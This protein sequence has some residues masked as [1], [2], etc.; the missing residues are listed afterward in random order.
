MG[1]ELAKAYVQIIPSAQGIK[2]SLT[3]AIGGEA[4]GAG[5]AAGQSMGGKLVGALKGVLA[6][7]AIGKALAATI[8]EGAA[9]EQSLGGVE[10]LFKEN[11]DTV[12]QY[13]SV[14]YK[15][16]GLSANDYMEQVT[17][18]SASLL[19]SLG[20]DT[21]AA[22]ESANSALVDMSDN[23][24]KFGTAPQSV[25][26]AYQGFAKQNYTMLD[27]LKLGYG[28]TKTEMQ[29]LLADAQKLSGVK[30]DISNLNDV[31]SA[32]HVVQDELNITGTTAKEASSTLSGSLAAMKSAFSN[33]LAGLTLGQDITPALEALADTAI[34][35]LVGNLLPAVWNII[36]ALPGGIAALIKAGAPQLA[37]ALSGILPQISAGISAGLPQLLA[38]LQQ[39]MQQLFA[40]FIANLPI[41]LQ[42]GEQL[43]QQIVN[44]ILMGVT[45]LTE[46]AIP[47][48]TAFINGLVASL[49]MILESGK[50]ILLS[51]LNGIWTA[52]PQLLLAAG[53][54]VL[55]MIGAILVN[56]PQII[57]AG[58]DLLV[59]LVQGFGTAYP[60]MIAAVG[61]L[62][63]NV[64]NAIKEVDWLQL[65]S[66]IV[67][68]IINGIIAMGG[69]L[70]DAMVSIAKSAFDAVANFFGIQSPST[71][72]RDKIGRFIPL[73]IA[74]GI[75]G[76]AK[77][78]SDAMRA[79]ADTTAGQ[80]Q[81]TLAVDVARSRAYAAPLPRDS[82]GFHVKQEIYAAKQT[83][84]EIAATTT[85][86]LR[87]ARWAMA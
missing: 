83:P 45:W 46:A 24:N 59:S 10:T 69:A 33:V 79:L 4:G 19:Q 56:L 34:T 52:L 76:N 78:V 71:L 49:P 27:N 16:A 64:W 62:M 23:W 44:G 7:A 43:V 47:T 63:T 82:G 81:A 9:M 20:G 21:A 70:W 60:N 28:G 55:S 68:G 87:N 14:A 6:A 15:T 86:Y 61:E 42:A 73:G 75:T 37:G 2:S 48:L 22:A 40:G 38:F 26:D 57:A 12:K 50:T 3:N 54:M 18:F 85:A 51:L 41:M 77:P 29:R 36:K 39:L 8:S 5:A 58:F 72:M 17:S 11:A 35:F 31:Y 74:V 66:N 80:M 53:N 65:G 13:A 67:A 32:I 25:Q 1:T 30:Y 84:V